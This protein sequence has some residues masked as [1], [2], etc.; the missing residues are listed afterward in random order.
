M[1]DVL[2]SESDQTTESTC[3]GSGGYEDTDSS[4]EI[5]L[6]IPKGQMEGHGLAEH[7]FTDTNE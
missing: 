7:R 4:S 5:G 6:R 2:N 1:L 3:D